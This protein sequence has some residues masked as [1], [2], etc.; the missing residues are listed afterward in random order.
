VLIDRALTSSSTAPAVADRSRE[1]TGRRPTAPVIG[2]GGVY[3][4]IKALAGTPRA[5]IVDAVPEGRDAPADGK[6]T[7]STNWHTSTPAGSTPCG[8]R[9]LPRSPQRIGVQSR[10]DMGCVLD[11][12]GG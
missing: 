12:D 8:P 9:R 10:T 2:E 1:L 5:A 6:S 3:L 11:R 7:P 4:R